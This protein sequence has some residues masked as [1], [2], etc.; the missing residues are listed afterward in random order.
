VTTVT[1]RELFDEMVAFASPKRSGVRFTVA[2]FTKILRQFIG[3]PDV[4]VK[5]HRDP[6]VDI[7]QVVISGIYDADDDEDDQPSISI[8][9]NYNP[10]QYTIRMKDIEWMKLCID[11]IECT[12]HELIHQ[13]Q[14]RSR[15]YDIGDTIFASKT[16]DEDKQEAQEYLGNLDEIEAYGY[17]IA[18]KYVSQSPIF[19]M[20]CVTFGTN[21]MVVRTLLEY[22][23]K[24][25]KHLRG[26]LY[27]KE[28]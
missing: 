23:L 7:D 6:N 3:G 19:K 12:G 21:H 10:Q 22:S 1:V 11:L 18:A 15:D 27:V 2:E 9:V 8:Y 28:V 4:K 14:Y 13:Q 5:T 26:E 25:F 17:S 20:Y 16:P 24:Y